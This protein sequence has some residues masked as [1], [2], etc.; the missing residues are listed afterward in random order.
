MVVLVGVVVVLMF[1]DNVGLL[2]DLARL[3][4]GGTR[5]SCVNTFMIAL[6]GW[7]GPVLIMMCPYLCVLVVGA[8]FVALNVVLGLNGVSVLTNCYVYVGLIGV[9]LIAVT[10]GV[11]GVISAVWVLWC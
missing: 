1:I 8:V 9:G 4:F 10:I 3:G 5:S 2:F 11:V 6:Y 7:G